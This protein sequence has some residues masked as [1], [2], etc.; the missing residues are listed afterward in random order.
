M[1][2]KTNIPMGKGLASCGIFLCIVAGGALL[3]PLPSSAQAPAIP[4]YAHK[5]AGRRSGYASW[6]IWLFGKP[7]RQNCWGTRTQSHGEVTSEN[8]TCGV[9]ISGAGYQ[10]AA[11]G[12]VG[13]RHD[14]QGLLFFFVRPGV[15]RLGVKIENRREHASS[16]VSAKSRWM[17]EKSRRA[18]HFSGSVGYVVKMIERRSICAVKIHLYGSRD[19]LL[20]Q[21]SLRVCV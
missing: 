14:S 1:P 19:K 3:I 10:L 6:G 17:N 7:D 4:R 15:K 11:S 9:S 21:G 20:G 5:V 12:S 13:S 2:I 8:V 16:W 18:A